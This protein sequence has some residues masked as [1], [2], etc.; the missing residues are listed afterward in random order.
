M[1]KLS[2]V[3]LLILAFMSGLYVESTYQVFGNRS[4]NPS[5]LNHVSDTLIKSESIADTH[6]DTLSKDNTATLSE[7]AGEKDPET[8]SQAFNTEREAEDLAWQYNKADYRQSEEERIELILDATSEQQL[9]D[10]LGD[11][12][13]RVRLESIKALGLI[14]S[15]ESLRILAQVFFSDKSSENRIATLQIFELR[16]D[17]PFVRDLLQYVAA[18]DSEQSVAELAALMI[19]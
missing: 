15:E 13:A 2:I 8:K 4:T 9:A 7:P 12:S 19:N 5:D 17:I 16:Q 6:T 1:R 18:H 11:D 14:D 10:F 3:L